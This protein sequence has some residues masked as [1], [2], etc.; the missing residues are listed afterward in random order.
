MTEDALTEAGFAVATASRGSQALKMLDA[1]DAAYRAVITDIDL[2][3]CVMGWDIARRARERS[4]EA[5]IVFVTG[6]GM[7]EWAT[8]GVPNIVLVTKPFAFLSF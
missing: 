4:P 7:T 1:P 6:G 2:G 8:R 3:D 5:A